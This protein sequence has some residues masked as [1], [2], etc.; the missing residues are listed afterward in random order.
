MLERFFE[1]NGQVW[2]ASLALLAEFWWLYLA[3]V[4]AGVVLSWWL[5]LLGRLR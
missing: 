4:A 3:I 5:A 2:D 1:L